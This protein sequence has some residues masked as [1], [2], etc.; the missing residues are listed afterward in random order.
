MEKISAAEFA[1]QALNASE[2]FY[3]L[4]VRTEAEYKQSRLATIASDN[5]PLDE[6]LDVMD[7]ITNHCANMRTYILCKAGVRA[8]FAG[9]DLEAA[10]AKDIVIVEGG[11]SALKDLGLPFKSGVISLERQYHILIGLFG[12]MGIIY[13][14]YLDKTWFALTAFVSFSALFHGLTGICGLKNIIAKMSWNRA[15]TLDLGAEISK[16][17]NS[18]QQRKVELAGRGH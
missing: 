10:G 14:L 5:V 11:T 17:V 7:T 9:Y 3:V 2:K 4:D 12:V 16:S 6:I 13:G 15:S 1:E 18:Y 8:E